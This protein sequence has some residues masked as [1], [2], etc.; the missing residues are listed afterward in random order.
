[1]WD[2]PSRRTRIKLCEFECLDPAHEASQLG[3][4]AL[5]F[6]LFRHQDVFGRAQRFAEIFRYLP[7]SVN[8]VVLTDVDFEVLVKVISVSLQCEAIQL[9]PDWTAD[10]IKS[11]RDKCRTGMRIL[12][13]MS[14]MTEENSFGSDEEFLRQ[15]DSLVDAYLLDSRRVGG[16]GQVADWQHCAHIVKAT[17]LP[18][19]LAGGL[20]AENVGDAIRVVQPF[21]VDVENGVSDRIPG[22]PLVKNMQKCR[23]FIAAVRRADLETGRV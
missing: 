17:R 8:K 13:V 11:L 21:G 16:T 4:D 22:G 19:F 5:G 14:A 12:K 1:M 20:S 3:V 6:H 2:E 23:E 9:Y 15:Y 18:V 7:R 10:Q